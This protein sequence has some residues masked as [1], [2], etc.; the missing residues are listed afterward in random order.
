ML[1]QSTEPTVLKVNSFIFGLNKYFFF[2]KYEVCFFKSCV[3]VL[4][5]AVVQV[6]LVQ[7]SCRGS[8][9]GQC[10][11]SITQQYTNNNP[12]D[13]TRTQTGLTQNFR[14]QNGYY[15]SWV[16]S[17]H[18]PLHFMRVAPCILISLSWIVVWSGNLFEGSN[19]HLSGRQ[20]HENAIEDQIQNSE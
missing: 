14:H 1:K 9:S 2:T 17:F 6:W 18:S 10:H 7:D 20:V 16:M 4:V 12:R 19:M 5:F 13:S 15:T 11:I 3:S 8:P